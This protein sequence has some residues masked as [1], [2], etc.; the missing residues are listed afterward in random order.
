MKVIEIPNKN[1]ITPS[2]MK[3][4][5]IGII[6]EWATNSKY[7]EGRIVQKHGSKLIA[8]GLASDKSFYSCTDT[9]T[10]RVEVLPK[11]TI[12]EI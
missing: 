12:L 4:G 9:S 11:G 3:D 1:T 5:E 7:Y 2:E 6:R 8:L 10:C